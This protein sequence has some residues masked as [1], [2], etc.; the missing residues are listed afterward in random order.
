MKQAAYIKHMLKASHTF[1]VYIVHKLHYVCKKQNET[2]FY[3][4]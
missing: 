2:L 4:V 1:I 3:R